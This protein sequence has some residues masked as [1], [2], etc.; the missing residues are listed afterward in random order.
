MKN[1][2]MADLT[3]KE[4]LAQDWQN[5]GDD[6]RVAM[7]LKV[8]KMPNIKHCESFLDGIRTLNPFGSMIDN[9]YKHR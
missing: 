9:I 3:D 1:D 2:V 6:L 4:S 7:G 5:V 8:R